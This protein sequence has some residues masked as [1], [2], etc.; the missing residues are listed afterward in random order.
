MACSANMPKSSRNS[1]LLR[2]TEPIMAGTASAS[3]CTRTW[4]GFGTTNWVIAIPSSANPT[5]SQK[6]PPT[7]TKFA[8]IGPATSAIMKE[9]PMVIPTTAIAF[10]RFSSAVRS[11]TSARITEPT[12]PAP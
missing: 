1:S 4:R 5:I 8:M 12:A 11:A 6:M 2:N 7:P 10:V 9:A 3:R